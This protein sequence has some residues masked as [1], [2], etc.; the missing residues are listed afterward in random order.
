MTDSPPLTIGL[1]WHSVNSDNLGVGALTVSQIAIIEKVAREAGV[2]VHFVVLGWYD[3]REP[4]VGGPAVTVERLRQRS[5]FFPRD[6]FLSRARRCDIVLDIGAGDSF[7]DIYGFRRFFFQAISKLQVLLAG[8]PLLLS[9]QTIGPF[10][11]AIPRAVARAIMRRAVAVVARDH[12]SYLLLRDFGL[13]EGRAIEATD[14]AF[15]LPHDPPERGPEGGRARVGIN[16][17]GLL[18]NGGYTGRNMFGLT[19]DYADL[20][21]RAI[22]AFAAREDCEVHLIGHVISDSFAIEDDHRVAEALAGEFQGVTVAPRFNS[23]SAAKSFIA[24]MDYFFGSRMHACIAAFSSG[25]PVVPLA[26]SRKFEGLFGSLGYPH[27]VDCRTLDGEDILAAVLGGFE[28]RMELARD[29]AACNEEVDRRLAGY[30]AVL[31]DNLLRL[32]GGR[33]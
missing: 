18:F 1:L 31:K 5:F 32:A 8:R 10:T 4:Y 11:R 22:G 33:Q 13:G 24:G 9:P 23:P 7:A 6:G 14:V 16:V 17:S 12:P 27:V 21:R 26:Y 28:R 2:P 30:E 15:R 29:V 20:M 19:V 3:R 25:I